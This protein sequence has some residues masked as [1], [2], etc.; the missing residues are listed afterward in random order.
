MYL[1]MLKV[2]LGNGKVQDIG[3]EVEE[4]GVLLAD[5]KAKLLPGPYCCPDCGQVEVSG[6]LFWGGIIF[7]T[8]LLPWSTGYL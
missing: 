4:G 6:Y 3:Q 2:A 1:L 8:A 7:T 5:A